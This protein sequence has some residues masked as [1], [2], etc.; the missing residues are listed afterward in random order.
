MRLRAYPLLLSFLLV[1]A[2]CGASTEGKFGVELFQL[3][4]ASC[5]SGDL[6]GGFGPPIGAGSNAALNLTDE[7]I[8]NTIR[9]GPGAMPSFSELSDD[10]IDSLVEFLR[11]MQEGG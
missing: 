8:G 5:H 2:S 9:V 11:W 4:C 6:S 1:L 3:T 7:Q 10:Q